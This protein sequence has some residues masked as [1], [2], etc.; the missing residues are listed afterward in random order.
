MYQWILRPNTRRILLLTI[1]IFSVSFIY[2]VS[3]YTTWS[4][5]PSRIILEDSNISC[6]AISAN[7]NNFVT[8]FEDGTVNLYNTINSGAIWSTKLTSTIESIYLSDD[9]KYLLVKDTVNNFNVYNTKSK[10]SNT[11]I[12]T[13]NLKNSSVSNIFVNKGFP[14]QIYI[15]MILPEKIQ[16]LINLNETKWQYTADSPFIQFTY[17]RDGRNLLA[18]DSDG[19]V[20][21]FKSTSP[22]PLWTKQSNL[23]QPQIHNSESGV[24]C[25]SGKKDNHSE[26]IIYGIDSG[27]IRSE[28][29]A[30]DIH[31]TTISSDGSLITYLD[32]NNQ[33]KILFGDDFQEKTIRV[34]ENIFD[35]RLSPYG[36]YVIISTDRSLSCFYQQ[37]PAPLWKYQEG[38]FE[39][40]D[41]S[42]SGT[43]VIASKNNGLY[44]FKNDTNITMIPGSRYL[45]GSSML[46]GLVL[47][48]SIIQK[49]YSLISLNNAKRVNYKNTIYNIVISLLTYYIFD[50]NEIAF[51]I[52]LVLNYI[53]NVIYIDLDEFYKVLYSFFVFTITSSI[54]GFYLGLFYWVRGSEMNLLFII[55]FYIILGTKI[56]IVNGILNFVKYLFSFLRAP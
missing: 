15:P 52:S 4:R 35:Y 55:I 40:I 9:G 26:I 16:L 8:G 33:L 54:L 42:H 12:Y 20:Y 6:I 30:Q 18:V 43:L 48:I 47:V 3:Y 7:T 51:I 17:T 2:A 10:E 19:M 53:I 56:G 21:N 34:N 44:I 14:T 27:Q 36:N 45:W 1:L 28:Y 24:L 29:I 41:V 37:R 49:K 11:P 22:E 50:Y 38:S 32:G 5:E 39:L 46:L 23:R 31:Q 13:T 25:L